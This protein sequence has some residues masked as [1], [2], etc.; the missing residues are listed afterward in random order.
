MNSYI[1][2]RENIFE[3]VED[4]VENRRKKYM[5]HFGGP[6]WR[7]SLRISCETERSEQTHIK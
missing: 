4:K 6:N 3:K 7:L 1:F 5:E 2:N